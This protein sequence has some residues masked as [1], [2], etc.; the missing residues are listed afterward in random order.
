MNDRRDLRADWRSRSGAADFLDVST[1]TIERRAVPWQDEPVPGKI[2]FK[3]LRL[4][5]DTRQ[6]RRYYQQDLEALLVP[7]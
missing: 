4:G 3:L 1:D 2:R 7:G 6:E 5:E